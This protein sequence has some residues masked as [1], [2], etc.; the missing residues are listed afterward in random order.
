MLFYDEW[1]DL[2]LLVSFPKNMVG[3][4]THMFVEIF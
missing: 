4:F 2:S 3:M 1:F